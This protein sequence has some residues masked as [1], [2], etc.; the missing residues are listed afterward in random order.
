MRNKVRKDLCRER[1][2][3][4]KTGGGKPPAPPKATSQRIIELFGD[5]P[6]IESGSVSSLSC[7]TKNVKKNIV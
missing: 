5:E 3:L 6:V 7:T 2:I 1:N 4:G